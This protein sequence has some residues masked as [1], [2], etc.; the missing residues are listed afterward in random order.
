MALA[1]IGAG[2][3][4]T[5][6][7]SMRLALEQLGFGPC[8]H[9]SEVTSNP[10][11]L[12]QWRALADG[13]KPDW[14]TIL[15]GYRSAVDWPSAYFWRELAAAYPDAKVLL[16]LRSAE[17]WYESMRNT[18]IPVIADTEDPAS[19][20]RWAISEGTFSG[21]LEDREHAIAVFERNTAEVQGAFGPERLL[22]Y[23]IGDGWTPLCA[24]LG[25]PVPDAPFPRSNSTAAFQA[26][27][28]KREEG[29]GP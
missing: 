13:R 24:F 8:H 2:F 7:D 14:E 4:R 17:S 6:T 10:D 22:T 29:K 12:R 1:V 20:G 16:T 23:H 25:V 19:I 26:A 27:V 18:I 21:R 5:G 3:G 15:A 11:Q 28:A 9:M